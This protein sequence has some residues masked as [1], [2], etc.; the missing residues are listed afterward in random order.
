[1]NERRHAYRHQQ[2][3]PQC[4]AQHRDCVTPAVHDQ[5]REPAHQADLSAQLGDCADDEKQ[6]GG[7]KI[8]PAVALS[9]PLVMSAVR[10]KPAAA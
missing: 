2:D 3:W 5:C 6:G 1:M 8:V 7:R 9:K 4:D 10:P